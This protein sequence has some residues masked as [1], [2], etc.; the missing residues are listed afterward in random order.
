MDTHTAAVDDKK[1]FKR[2]ARLARLLDGEFRFPGTGW[3]FGLDPLI[4]LIPG[5]GDT[6][7]AGL[8]LWIVIQ[9][10]QLGVPTGTLTRMLGNI[11]VDFIAGLVPILGDLVDAGYKANT[12]NIALLERSLK[13]D[14]PA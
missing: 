5:A 14:R 13:K 10:R 4:G 12:R 9:A 3:R 2:L 11:A 1:K 8:S 7:S 6:V